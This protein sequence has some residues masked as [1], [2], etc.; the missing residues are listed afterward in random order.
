MGLSYKVAALSEAAFVESGS[1][2]LSRVSWLAQGAKFSGATLGMGALLTACGAPD[3]MAP[4]GST[5]APPRTIEVQGAEYSVT[6]VSTGTNQGF[7]AKLNSNGQLAVTWTDYSNASVVN[8]KIFS[9]AR[10]P[11]NLVEVERPQ[12]AVSLL[13]SI[14]NDDAGNVLLAWT[15][16]MGPDAPSGLRARR[17]SAAG[18]AQGNSFP[19]VPL[20]N[21]NPVIM[22]SV[23][24]QSDGS[25]R[26][27][28]NENS[29]SCGVCAR[30][31]GPD[32]VQRSVM[33]L[34]EAGTSVLA[35]DMA[36]SAQGDWAWAGLLAGN[37]GER[38]VRFRY[39]NVGTGLGASTTFSI[40]NPG[41]ATGIKVAI[42][43][44]DNSLVVWQSN[45]GLRGMVLKPDGRPQSAQISLNSLPPGSSFSATS[46]EAGAFVVAW[47]E[48][49]QIRSSL[50]DANGRIISSN[51][52]ISNG[53]SDN[54]EVTVTANERGQ[55]SY[56]WRRAQRSPAGYNLVG[57]NYQI[58]Y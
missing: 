22:G 49:G 36:D 41:T 15:N 10:T 42:L 24:L 30:T 40:G 53:T 5:L 35:S 37:N 29:S 33:T 20:E 17:Y 28:S 43:P 6:P 26:V 11:G 34:S 48:A 1:G 23:S 25:F 14:S 4:D 51:L 27:V 19:I 58:R 32:N 39:F 31:Y 57:R 16:S 44:N 7:A 56:L 45:Q 21:H 52:E 3:N 2:I 47:E 50:L 38:Q 55:V 8:L 9:D 13:P 54:H 12:N 46:D 18:Q